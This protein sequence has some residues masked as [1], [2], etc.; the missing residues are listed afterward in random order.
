MATG[1]WIKWEKGLLKK[2]EIANIAATLQISRYEVAA[3]CME[4]WEWADDNTKN[5]TVDHVPR[6]FID[7]LLSVR[8]FADALQ[9]IGWLV[10]DKT[11]VTFPRFDRHNGKCAKR[12]AEDAE[13]KRRNRK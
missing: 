10:A 9:S 13:R 7:D 3:R 1:Q 8:G 4:L 6:A 2:P 12:R 11:G 5:G